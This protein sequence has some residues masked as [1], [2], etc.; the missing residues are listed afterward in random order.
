MNVRSDRISLEEA[1][2]PVP[3]SGKPDRN[4]RELRNGLSGTRLSSRI[5]EFMAK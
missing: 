4:K 5:S 2:E 1:Y 3:T